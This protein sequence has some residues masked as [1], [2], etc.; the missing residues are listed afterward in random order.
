MES[1]PAVPAKKSPLPLI[2]ALIV[3]AVLSLCCCA[4]SIPVFLGAG[5]WETSGIIGNDTGK[6]PQAYGLICIGAGIIPWAIPLVVA[7]LRR[8]K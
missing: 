1:T 3:A 2:I 5:T 7:I 6:L 8:R 4:P